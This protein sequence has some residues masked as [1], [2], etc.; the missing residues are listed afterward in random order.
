[1]EFTDALK[2]GDLE[3]VRSFPKADLHDH[4]V[5]GGSRRYLR[6]H[7]GKDIQ[8]IRKPLRSMEEMHAWAPRNL[9]GLADTAEGRRLL[10]RAA[11]AQAAEDGKLVNNDLRRTADAI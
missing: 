11:F 10:I 1:M 3:A 4:F 6:E 9:A 2:I 8:P 7:S 5:L